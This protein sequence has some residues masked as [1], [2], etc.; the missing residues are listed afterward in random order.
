M[1][2]RNPI[3][4][5]LLSQVQMMDHSSRRWSALSINQYI[6]KQE[7]GIH[8]S[9]DSTIYLEC[10]IFREFSKRLYICTGS[11]EVLS[12][13]QSLKRQCW[14]IKKDQRKV[15]KTE[16]I[17]PLGA[18]VKDIINPGAK[19]LPKDDLT[20]ISLFNKNDDIF[21]EQPLFQNGTSNFPKKKINVLSRH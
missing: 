18:F 1:I 17:Q 6:T 9:R 13:T 19:G 7:S 3:F 14:V 11:R 2:W 15:W 12:K 16:R 21:Y 8:H 20:L 10:P 5:Y 4:R